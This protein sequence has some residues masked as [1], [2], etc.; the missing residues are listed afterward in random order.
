MP[1]KKLR[2]RTR[3]KLQQQSTAL[4]DEGPQQQEA[5]VEERKFEAPVL[6]QQPP[7]AE[8]EAEQTAALQRLAEAQ[9]R[10]AALEAAG[11]RRDPDFD[12]H[13]AKVAWR[14]RD[15]LEDKRRSGISGFTSAYP[16]QETY[17]PPRLQ[18]RKPSFD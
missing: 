9:K 17:S 13:P 10:I 8:T 18:P 15:E 16:E 5:S 7:A 6:N 4:V 11:I 1:Q 2:Q 14:V 12:L 3:K